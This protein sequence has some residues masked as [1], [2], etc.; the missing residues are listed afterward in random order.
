MKI[1]H[2][3]SGTW[4]GNDTKDMGKANMCQSVK[5]VGKNRIWNA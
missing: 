5:V 4:R 2:C 1:F 3:R